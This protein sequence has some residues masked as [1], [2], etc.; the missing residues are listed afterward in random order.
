MMKK[1][2]IITSFLAILIFFGCSKDWLS[3]VE[4]QSKLLEVNYYS[5]PQ[6][7]LNGLIGVY[8]MIK[9]QYFQGVWASW[10]LMESLPSDDAVAVGGGP[11]DRPELHSVDEYTITP[12]TGG[13]I[14]VWDRCYFGIYRA[15]VVIA[16]TAGS[17]DAGILQI[18]AEAK[19]LRAYLYFDLVRFWGQVPLVTTELTPDQ[20]GQPKVTEQEIF[21]QIVADLKDAVANLYDKDDPRYPRKGID[22]YRVAKYAAMGLLGKVYTYMASPYYGLGTDNYALAAAQLKDVIDN[23]NYQL[24]T[25]YD[26]IWWYAN[27]FNKETLM[28]VSY[29]PSPSTATYWGNGAESQSNVI[30]QLDGPR[31]IDVNSTINPGW[32]FDMITPELV[33][34]YKDAGDSVRLH[35]T[36]LAEWQLRQI[37]LC[38]TCHTY[39][40]SFDKQPGYT[41]YYTKKRTT[42]KAQNPAAAVWSYSN[43]ERV[44]RLGDIYLLYAEALNRQSSPDDATAL[45]YVNLLRERALLTDLPPQT[46]DNLFKT[47]QKERRLELAQEGQRFFDLVRWEGGPGQTATTQ[48]VPIGFQV[49]KH[50]HFPIPANEI[51]YSH[52]ALLQNPAYE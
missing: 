30:I 16:R 4:P 39:I 6:E 36:A 24:L 44:L 18:Q 5:T 48:L 46:G 8:S 15:N 19:A 34:A 47:I 22:A 10:Y 26:K 12:I 20:Y 25:D 14:N 52:G 43:N 13:L 37:P 29:G 9:N 31:G 21:N 3:N 51:S 27:E 40:H 33:Q 1:S 50:E 11:N 41:G 23:G 28:E 38:D 32:G 17:T 45:H 7:A 2:I 35:G 49:G 42:W